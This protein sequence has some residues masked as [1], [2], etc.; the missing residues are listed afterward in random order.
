L[1]RL[2]WSV[3]AAAAAADDVLRLDYIVLWKSSIFYCVVVYS[4][5]LPVSHLY[6]LEV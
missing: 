1:N 4:T 5:H 3:A 2:L 6:N